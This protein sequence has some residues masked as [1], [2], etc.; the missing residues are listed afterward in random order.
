MHRDIRTLLFF[1]FLVA[2]A[3][4]SWLVVKPFMAGMIWA[5]VLV[6][7]FKPVQERLTARL[8]GRSWAASLLVTL[9]VATF[10]IVPTIIAAVQVVQGSVKAYEWVQAAYSEG[11]T[12][13]G[14]DER[15]PHLNQAV[16][17]GMDLIGLSD[18]DARTAGINLV[19]KMGAVAAAKAPG[20]VGD[21]LGL[22]FS[23]A[24]TLAMMFV[25]FSR[26]ASVAAAVSKVLPLPRETADRIVRELGLMTRTL[27]VSVGLTALVQAF[28]GTIAF[29]VLGVPNAFTLGAAMFFVAL[30]PGG[31]ALVWLPV[32]IWLGA[33]GHEWKAVMMV[34]WGA[35]II[36]TI[37]NILRPY[38]A[39]D[40]VKLPT[41]M[42]V[43]GLLGGLLAFG[44]VG[45]FVGPIALYLLRELTAAMQQEA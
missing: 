25:F 13:L 12:N 5:A 31:P 41:T 7:T 28:L 9:A 10:I 8:R 15:W 24:V 2:V 36:G 32:A 29:L 35:G 1:I 17:R 27:F 14:A 34:A 40:G 42:L 44:I 3:W 19:K 22:V 39:K 4:C 33:S 21:A 38:F 37:D 43:L 45:L 20:L 23:F 18:I 6:C 30:I 16:H 26:G 11:G